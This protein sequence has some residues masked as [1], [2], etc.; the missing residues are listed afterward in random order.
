LSRQ[1]SPALL[2]FKLIE[3]ETK[4]PF[5]GSISAFSRNQEP[6][7]TS[8]ILRQDC[9]LATLGNWRGVVVRLSPSPCKEIGKPRIFSAVLRLS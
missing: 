6:T 9:L 2:F 3:V 1:P 4:F 7:E 5:E 8:V